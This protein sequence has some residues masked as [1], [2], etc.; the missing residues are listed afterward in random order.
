MKRVNILASI[1]TILLCITL[2]FAWYIKGGITPWATDDYPQNWRE[3]HYDLEK[4]GFQ[5]IAY[6]PVDDEDMD[7]Y[8][9]FEYIYE[10]SIDG[11]TDYGK[12]KRYPSDAEVIVSYYQTP[13]KEIPLNSEDI[14]NYDHETIAKMFQDSGFTNL[15]IEEYTDLDPALGLDFQNEVLLEDDDTFAQGQ[16]YPR[17]IPI[18]IAVH[19]P[20]P[21]YTVT[22]NVDYSDSTRLIGPVRLHLDGEDKQFMEYGQKQI[23]EF[24]VGEGEHVLA[25]LGAF[26]TVEGRKMSFIVDADM[27][28]NCTLGF[29]GEVTLVEITCTYQKGMA[30]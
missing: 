2:F 22:I 7:D 27:V 13:R 19:R 30:S 8:P 20:L 17:S 9:W 16:E 14:Q 12:W 3:V 10:I 5:K 11:D 24:T 28:I 25:F 21:A 23:Y 4:A 15:Y 6:I 18:L 1:F 29:D 26:G